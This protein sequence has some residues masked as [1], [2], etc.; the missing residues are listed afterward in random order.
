MTWRR[1]ATDT[2]SMQQMQF[3]DVDDS[4][5]AVG[6][7]SIFSFWIQ[8]QCAILFRVRL[9]LNQFT[10]L[11][12]IHFNVK[13]III[14]RNFAPHYMRRFVTS[15]ET[16]LSL[17]LYIALDF[18][19]PFFYSLGCFLLK[20][21][22]CCKTLSSLSSQLLLLLLLSLHGSWAWCVIGFDECV[23]LLLCLAQFNYVL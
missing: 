17:L 8:R 21:H 7:Q 15:F 19:T 14:L 5:V 9:N 11:S 23:A 16:N 3:V 12:A 2:N 18:Y 20:E 22:N 13:N 6:T 1:I 4:T 10:I